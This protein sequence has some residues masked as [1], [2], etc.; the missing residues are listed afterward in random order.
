MTKDTDGLPEVVDLGD[1]A[2]YSDIQDTTQRSGLVEGA[3]NLEEREYERVS[4]GSYQGTVLFVFRKGGYIWLLKDNYGSCNLCDGLIGNPDPV[5]YARSMFRDAYAFQNKE[6]TKLF[7]E[8]RIDNDFR[9]AYE[10]EALG[11]SAIH[12]VRSL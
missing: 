5:Q 8:S 3:L 12:A 11:A 6:K 4:T 10:W 7:L 2:D 9:S 1:Y